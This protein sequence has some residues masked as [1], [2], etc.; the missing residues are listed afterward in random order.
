MI[1]V[2]RN[3]IGILNFSL[4]NGLCGQTIYKREIDGYSSGVWWPAAT[5]LT[6]TWRHILMNSGFSLRQCA[7]SIP[8]GL[9]IN[10]SSRIS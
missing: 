1:E 2:S 6:S 10:H 9:D 7:V 3:R 5:T 8:Q 4:G